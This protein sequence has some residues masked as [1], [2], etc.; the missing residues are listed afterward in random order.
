[1]ARQ[2]PPE[3]VRTGT[4]RLSLTD[5]E[6]RFGGVRAIRHADLHV[7]PGEVH[8]LVGEN[9]A[10]K[11]T[12]IKIL[13]G[14]E[15]SDAG[16]ITFD[17]EPVTIRNA[18]DAI[19]L[20]VATVY[21]E[22][23]LF[24]QL[25]VA[26]NI[27]LGREIR[28][29]RTID[30]E[31][32][33]QQVVESLAAFGLGQEF[34]TR[35]VEELSAA[36]Q[37]QVSIAKALALDAK[38]LILD[39]PSAILTDAEIENLFTAIRRLAAEGV[40]II[41]ISHRLD[42]LFVI[43]DVVTVM[44]DGE[45]LG[46]FEIGDLDV[47]A[48]SDLMVGGEFAES[49][50]GANDARVGEVR[51]S[52]DHLRSRHFHD[53]SIDVRAGE[54]VV[55]Y[56]LVGSG[57][58]E[59]AAATYGQ[60]PITGGSMTL[61]G[62]PYLPANPRQAQQRGLAMLPANRKKEGMFSFQPISFNITIGS[63]RLF[64]KAGIF[65]DRG[66][67]AATADKMIQTLA[68]KTNSA[69]RAIATLSGG[70]A[71]KVVLARQLVNS[72]EVLILAEPSQGVDIGAKDEIHKIIDQLCDEGTAVLIATS[73]LTEAMRVADRLIVIRNGTTFTEFGRGA[74]QT[75]VLAAASGEL[76]EEQEHD[77]AEEVDA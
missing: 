51:L 56:G 44:R 39:E 26:E 77:L 11:S 66:K 70:N 76:T 36:Q 59:I 53:V 47:G 69:A 46:T 54:V 72:P 14:A 13:A 25:T 19:D 1:M 20:G 7:M 33:N 55:L 37:Q 30:W 32:Q 10:G 27:F 35:K 58:A 22:A 34:V 65:V 18:A 74:S 60:E 43:A 63:L 42:E 4:T 75:A 57:V 71:Q 67:E 17:G 38:V 21:Q 49:A 5:I 9:G 28:K 68:I 8:A 52:L 40:S 64:R 29:G 50:S 15:S 31:A 23:Q 41:Y 3:R 62:K 16:A 45:T 24:A 73:D 48:L 6:K 12:L 2:L 61:G